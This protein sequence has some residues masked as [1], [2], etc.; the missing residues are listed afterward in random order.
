MDLW[1]ELCL[2]TPRNVDER[3][4]QAKSIKAH[5]TKNLK[6]TL[7]L[8]D[9]LWHLF[10]AKKKKKITSHSPDNWCGLMWNPL[11]VLGP[12]SKDQKVIFKIQNV[13]WCRD[14]MH[15]T[16]RNIWKTEEIDRCVAVLEQQCFFFLNNTIKGSIIWLIFPLFLDIMYCERRDPC[17]T[18]GKGSIRCR[19][20]WASWSKPHTSD[21][22]YPASSTAIHFID[23]HM[24]FCSMSRP[25]HSWMQCKSRNT[26]FDC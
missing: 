22:V 25:S 14:S 3:K 2:I 21:S 4:C 1:C 24:K 20:P 12:R 18:I 13:D 17:I 19:S 8:N 9:K 23:L 15:T 11:H 5:L 10:Q 16:I 26:S 7:L 6:L